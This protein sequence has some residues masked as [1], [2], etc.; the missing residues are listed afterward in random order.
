MASALWVTWGIE[1]E[2]TEHSQVGKGFQKPQSATLIGVALWICAKSLASR[3]SGDRVYSPSLFQTSPAGF[4]F[5]EGRS[6][7]VALAGRL[8][9]FWL[10]RTLSQ[11]PL[12][13]WHPLHS[14]RRAVVTI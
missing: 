6:L 13:H 4:P 11:Q 14:N 5:F 9:S 12:H 7:A 2:N 10:G 1:N 8:C 3:N